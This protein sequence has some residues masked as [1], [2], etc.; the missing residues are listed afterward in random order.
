MPATRQPAQDSPTSNTRSAQQEFI[1]PENSHLLITTPRHI[2]AWDDS[3]IHTIFHSKAGGIVA[4]REAKDGSG[5][6][7]VASNNVV[8][9]H[10]TRR[11]KDESWGLTAPR[12]EVRHLEYSPDAKSLFL[13]TTSDGAIQHYSTEK[14]RLLDPAQKHH[15]APLA[16]AIS[17]TGHLLLSASQDP[18]TVFLKSLAHDTSPLVIQPQA[19]DA[20]VCC[21][22]FHP[23]RPNVFL[24]AFRDGTVAAYDATKMPRHNRGTYAN[25]QSVNDGEIA[26]VQRVHRTSAGD[27]VAAPIAGVAFLP[28]Y[29][30]RV[31][32][33]GRDGRCKLVDLAKGGETMRTWHTKAPLTSIAVW[34]LKGKAQSSSVREALS[35]HRRNRSSGSH[36]IGGPTSTNSIIAVS[37]LDGK[38]QLYDSVGLL[39]AQRAI[40]S[41]EEP[42]LSLEWAK[43]AAPASHFSGAIQRHFSD[44]ESVPSILNAKQ[45]VVSS[46]PR[47]VTQQSACKESTPTKSGLGLPLELK[48]KATSRQFTVHPDEEAQGTVRRIPSYQGQR[49]GPTHVGDYQDLFSPIKTSKVIDQSS[50]KRLVSSS[51]RRRPRVSSRTFIK[52]GAAEESAAAAGP[53]VGTIVV[54]LS[55]RIATTASECVPHEDERMSSMKP[56]QPVDSQASL[57]RKAKRRITFQPSGDGSTWSIDSAS[58]GP[59]DPNAGGLADLRKLHKTGLCDQKHGTLSSYATVRRNKPVAGSEG[60]S[61]HTSQPASRFPPH[62]DPTDSIHVHDPYTWPTDS[63][64]DSLSNDIWFTSDSDDDTSHKGRRRMRPSVRSTARQSSR[65][66]VH[67]KG[68]IST[69]LPTEPSQNLGKLPARDGYT[70]EDGDRYLTAQSHL[71]PVAQLSSVSADVRNLFPRT[72]SLSPNQRKRTARRDHARSPQQRPATLTEVA[73]NTAIGKP[74][75]SPWDKVKVSKRLAG[76]QSSPARKQGGVP[77]YEDLYTMAGALPRSEVQGCATCPETNARLRDLEGEMAQ[78][79]GEVL[80]I[81]AV[82]RRNGLPLPACLR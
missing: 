50:A 59:S 30:T 38:L 43:G 58:L 74:S 36:T 17:P 9:M 25:Q 23:E 57:P 46:P 48:N 28:G 64:A 10:D 44:A 35:K 60:S 69:R 31:V 42:I 63:A 7:A 75:R 82:M 11:G 21:A 37:R 61:A 34:S 1:F 4:A 3:G 81:K 40:S 6:L 24:L 39:R 77:V 65:P 79:R 76:K 2:F 33:A 45:R 73:V 72:S 54:S 22:A 68:M 8:V 51:P 15:A 41:L 27:A 29:K 53:P 26:H 71:S 67:I 52:D 32:T 78:L 13:S 20:A 16:L 80:A 14:Q 49:V 55:P 18:P 19:S 70:D 47:I 5:V 12:E 56:K 66:R 62:K